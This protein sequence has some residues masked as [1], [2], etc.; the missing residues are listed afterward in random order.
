[1]KITS[2]VF[3]VGGGAHS[4]PEDGAVYLVFMEG[5]AALIDAGYGP[6]VPRI[7][8]NIRGCRVKT[9]Q[10]EIILLTH[11]HF[12]HT[13]GVP[14]LRQWTDAAIG[15]H[16]L[17]APF[18]ESGNSAVTAASWYGRSAT[19][20]TV[21]RKLSG[22]VQEISL[23]RQRIHMVHIPGH[24][25]GSV[26]YWVESDGKRVLFGQ[27]VHGPL[28]ESLLSDPAAYR[29]SLQILMDLEADILCE[30]HYGIYWGKEN[31][32]DFIKSFLA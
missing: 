2:E 21:D 10:I 32:R 13:G 22:A 1:M 20:F 12:D 15:A 7:I 16:E 18:L 19:P 9:E 30:G 27:D 26:A 24:S 17:D 8:E 29:K 5:K 25:P 11:C 3:Q 14:G 31:V 4:S 28:D 6:S 23:G